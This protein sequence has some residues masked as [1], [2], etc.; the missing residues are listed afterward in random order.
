MWWIFNEIKKGFLALVQSVI[1]NAISFVRLKLYLQWTLISVCSRISDGLRENAPKRDRH[2]SATVFTGF[3]IQRWKTQA[4]VRQCGL[5]YDRKWSSKRGTVTFLTFLQETAHK[6]KVKVI[7]FKK[8]QNC[9]QKQNHW[10]IFVV[11]YG[12]ESCMYVVRMS[13]IS[14]GRGK[15]SGLL[16]ETSGPRSQGWDSGVRWS[17]CILYAQDMNVTNINFLEHLLKDIVNVRWKLMHYGV[18]TN[19]AQTNGA[20]TLSTWQRY[21]TSWTV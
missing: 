17:I 19:N 8:T 4:C 13:V 2:S 18:H 6:R 11:L 21:T 5:R 9:V 1:C 14:R 3:Y 10:I 12:Y 15:A 16:G 20:N 7:P